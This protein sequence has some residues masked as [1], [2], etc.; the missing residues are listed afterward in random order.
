[1][2]AYPFGVPSGDRPA[3]PAA[4]APG[5]WPAEP[6]RDGGALAVLAATLLVT[7]AIGSPTDLLLQDTLKSAIVAFGTLLAALLFAW[8][9]RRRTEPLRWHAVLGLPLLLLAHALGSMAWSHAYLA[10]VE[11]VRWFLF[12]LLAWLGLNTLSRER[13]PL[14]AGCT[15]GGAL[16]ASAWAMAQFWGGVTWFSQG[17]PPASTFYNRNFFAEYAVCA[18]PFGMLLLARAGSLRAAAP[19]AVALGVVVTAILMT[20]TRAALVALGAQ[21]LLAPLLAWRCRDALPCRHWTPRLR[22]AVAALLAFTVLGLGTIPTSNPQILEEGHGATPLQRGLQRARAIQP[23]GPTVDMRVLMWR[24]TADLIRAH[25]VAGVGAGAWENEIP[26]YQAEGAELEADYYAHNE[27]L[28][29]VAE[30]GLAGWLFL[31]LLA[32]WLLRAGLSTWRSAGEVAQGERPWRATLLCS[33]L[34]LMVVSQAGFP[35]RLAGTGALFAMGLGGLAA[36]DARLAAA[37]RLLAPRLHWSPAVARIAIAA[38]AACLVLAVYLTQRAVE[39]ER[40]LAGAASIALAIT[41]SGDWNDPRHAPARAEMLRLVREGIA[42]HPHYRKITSIVADEL[43]HWGDAREALWIWE[44][45]LASR[46]NVVALLTSAA[47]AHESLGDTDKA[48]AYLARARQ[49]QPRAP[50]VRSLEVSLHAR[51]GDAGRAMQLAQQ[52]LADGVSDYDLVD[53][54]FVLAWRSG[55]H[56]LAEELLARRMALWPETRVR[57]LMQRGH[58]AAGRGDTAQA[59]L[60]FREALA[61]AAPA[62]RAALARELPTALQAQVQEPSEGRGQ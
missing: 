49:I 26:R 48:L 19:W 30:Y 47:R 23:A 20:G 1:M 6:L 57:G 15:M 52:A 42:L 61:A 50:S 5:A 3:P 56:A 39:S 51:R 25:P 29:L 62:E 8:A 32:A 41:D 38:T 28:Q 43:A 2:T 9:Q 33:L 18:L 4:T 21:L 22:A 17:P 54:Y 34:A 35:W 40:K 31:L 36:S 60:A 24:A 11:A 37:G 27:F 10:G 16:V 45:V 53:T 58:M 55:R 46:P 13:L 12:A 44:S 59:V 14:L 7:P